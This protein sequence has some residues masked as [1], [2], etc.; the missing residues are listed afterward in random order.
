MF[1]NRR[2][3]IMPKAVSTIGTIL[4]FGTTSSALTKLCP[5]TSY[6]DLIGDPEMIEV[7]DLEDTQQ[8]YIPGIKSIDMLQFEANYTSELWDSLAENE[9]K[10]GYFSLEFGESG[11]DGVFN[12]QGTYTLGMPGKGNNEARTMTINIAPSTQITKGVN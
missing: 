4:K 10:A 11:T 3:R 1:K 12:W 8:T 2:N 5:I 6:P 9:G 7:T